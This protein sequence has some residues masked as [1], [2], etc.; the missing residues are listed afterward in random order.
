V[1]HQSGRTLLLC[2]GRWQPAEMMRDAD[3]AE[4]VGTENICANFAEALERAKKAVVA[5]K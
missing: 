5:Q 4:H 1:V 2:G 3:F